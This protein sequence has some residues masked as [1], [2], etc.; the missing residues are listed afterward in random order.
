MAGLPEPQRQKVE[1]VTMDMSEEFE[2]AAKQAAPEAAIVNDKFHVSKHLNEAVDNVRKQEHQK[3]LERKDESLKVTKYL[4]LQ[5][6]PAEGEQAVSFAA[7][8]ARNLK[9]ARAW[10]YKKNFVEF[11]AQPDLPAAWS[12]STS[13]SAPPAARNWSRSRKLPSPSKGI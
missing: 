12:S 3:L 4:W 6:K 9:T 13:G 10:L 11:W 7:L 2:T 8:C 1:G 5:G